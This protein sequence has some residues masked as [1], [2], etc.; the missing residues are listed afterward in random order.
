MPFWQKDYSELKELRNHRRRTKLS[1]FALP[2]LKAEG[3]SPF[4]LLSLLHLALIPGRAEWQSP[5]AT[6]DSHQPRDGPAR[7]LHYKPDWNEQPLS[8]ISFP[9]YIYF[10]QAQ[11]WIFFPFVTSLLHIYHF[12]LRW[13]I[14]LLVCCLLGFFTSFLWDFPYSYKINLFLLPIC[15]LWLYFFRASA[16]KLKRI[17][18]KLF[19]FSLP[20]KNHRF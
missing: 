18:E 20:N 6:L 7:S 5:E 13:Y 8:S 14:S 3:E 15:L 9:A 12:L 4:A 19:Y 11:S 1:V 10:P 16:T 2:C 17:N